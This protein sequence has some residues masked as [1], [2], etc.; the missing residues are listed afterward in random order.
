[1]KRICLPLP[2]RPCQCRLEWLGENTKGAAL[3]TC[4]LAK[5]FNVERAARRRSLVRAVHL[6]MKTSSGQIYAVLKALKAKPAWPS[7]VDV[8]G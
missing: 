3:K 8:P 1:M 2:V 5:E 6:K 4:L 7:A